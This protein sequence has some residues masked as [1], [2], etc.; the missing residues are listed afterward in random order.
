[1]AGL[2][3]AFKEPFQCKGHPTLPVQDAKGG[4]YCFNCIIE[5]FQNHIYNLTA[6]MLDDRALAEDVTQEALVSAYRAFPRFRGDNLRAWLLRIAANAAR[7]ILRIR[8]AHPSISIDQPIDDEDEE[9]PGFDIPSRD[10]SPEEHALRSELRRA[11]EDCLS[12]LPEGQKLAVTL[13]DVQGASY[14]EAAQTMDTSLGTVKSR[15]SRA[16]SALRDC[17]RVKGELLPSPFRQDG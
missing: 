6:R 10:E 17:L 13:V 11:I 16:R 3:E 14:E 2:A 12:K 9:S 5:A 4:R 15:L 7:D 1:V 8:K